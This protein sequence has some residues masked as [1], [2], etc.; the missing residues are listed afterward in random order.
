MAVAAFKSSSRRG[1]QS[2][3]STPPNTSSSGSARSSSNSNNNNN[4]NRAPIRR[5]RSVSAFSRRPSLD[6][7]TDF[8]N[9][10]DN[11][12]F[13]DTSQSNQTPLLLEASSA[14]AKGPSGFGA[15][16]RSAARNA[17]SGRSLSRV[18]SGRR[19][20]S[21]SQCPVSRRHFNYSTSEVYARSVKL[22]FK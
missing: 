20:R 8:L 1:N 17:E 15:R 4:N 13:D 14:P 22:V 5:S 16:G 2:S 11:P 9:K 18:D 10:R 19:T 7:D 6:V 21:A 3:T 12:L